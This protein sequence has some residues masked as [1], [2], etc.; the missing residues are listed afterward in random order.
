MLVKILRH[1]F[2]DKNY[3]VKIVITVKIILARNTLMSHL[4]FLSSM[5]SYILPIFLEVLNSQLP[6]NISIVGDAQ[7]VPKCSHSKQYTPEPS[8]MTMNTAVKQL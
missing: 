6:Q 4:K 1:L 5:V 3:K 7:S 2:R 8:N